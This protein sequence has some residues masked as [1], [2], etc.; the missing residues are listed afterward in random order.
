MDPSRD[1]I[2]GCLFVDYGNDLVER[3]DKRKYQDGGATEQT[4]SGT[5][6]AMDRREDLGGKFP[7]ADSNSMGSDPS[8]RRIP[9]AL[10]RG[11]T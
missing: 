1:R 8:N 9:P 3:R 2:C 4:Q 6:T 7:R 11:T 5:V 10:C